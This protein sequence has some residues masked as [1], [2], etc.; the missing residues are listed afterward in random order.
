MKGW[1]A[2]HADRLLLSPKEAMQSGEASW[3]V[4]D[5]LLISIQKS[6]RNRQRR[7]EAKQQSASRRARELVR[8]SPRIQKGQGTTTRSSPKLCRT[9]HRLVSTWQPCLSQSPAPPP[10]GIQRASDWLAEQPG[11]PKITKRSTRSKIGSYWGPWRTTKTSTGER[12]LARMMM[13]AETRDSCHQTG[14]AKGFAAAR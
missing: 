4:P 5:L 14:R 8:P 11:L 3:H 9:H 1:S 2:P 13:I 7:G 10:P 12:I 6:T